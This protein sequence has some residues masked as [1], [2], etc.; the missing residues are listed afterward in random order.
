MS[1]PHEFSP[2][3]RKC[4]PP[5]GSADCQPESQQSQTHSSADPLPGSYEPNSPVTITSPCRPANWSARGFLDIHRIVGDVEA[6]ERVAGHAQVQRHCADG[7]SLRRPLATSRHA[8]PWRN[9]MDL[10]GSLRRHQQVAGDRGRKR[11]WRCPCPPCPRRCWRSASG[12]RRSRSSRY[13]RI[14]GHEHLA[15][16]AAAGIK[17]DLA[18]IFRYPGRAE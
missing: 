16:E 12:V 6:L 4:R 9:R 2:R 5:T 8:S 17:E 7:F 10:P 18:D 13:S 3:S 1:P 11:C 14:G 15:A